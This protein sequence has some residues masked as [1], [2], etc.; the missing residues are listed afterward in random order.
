MLDAGQTRRCRASDSRKKLPAWVRSYRAAGSCTL[1]VST[2]SARKPG[3][4]L[5][6]FRKLRINRPAPASSTSDSATS[7]TTS[8]LSTRAQPAAAAVASAFAQRVVRVARGDEG[9][10]QPERDPRRQRGDHGKGH[11]RRI[12]RDLVQ[13]GNRNPIAHQREQPAMAQ[14]GDRQPRDAAGGREHETL[15]EHLSHEPPA[16]G[17]Q[18]RSHADLPRAG[19]APRQQQVCDVHA[20]DEKHEHD[21]GD[22][23]EERRPD[24]AHHLLLKRNEHHGSACVQR[25]VLFLQVGEQAA[26]LAV[27][28]LER[29]T[30]AQARDA[31]RAVAA[32]HCAKLFQ[33]LTVGNQKVGLLTGDSEA[34]RHHADDRPGPATGGERHPEHVRAAAEASLP[35]L[36]A[37]HDDGVVAAEIFRGRVGAAEHGL[38]SQCGK[39]VV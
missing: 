21:G 1:A 26:H 28:L 39:G 36:V 35:E 11:N 7:A 24:L 27:R 15:R 38:D 4:T 14:R 16:F 9:R 34:R 37:Q 20:G 5:C 25:R 29:D 23:R 31:V 18:G 19:G 17:A 8:V 10:N 13:P 12:E 22:E 6:S 33:C 32:A 3:S 30:V 2:P